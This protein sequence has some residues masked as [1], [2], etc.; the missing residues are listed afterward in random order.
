[1]SQAP[2][3]TEVQYN[4]LMEVVG[5]GENGLRDQSMLAIS[6]K[7]GL[8]AGEISNLNICDVIG[9]DG[10]FRNT[11]FV[12]PGKTKHSRELPFH[13]DVK[14]VLGKY[15]ET[16]LWYNTNEPLF[17]SRV[18]MRFTKSTINA[19][20]KRMFEKGGLPD[21]SSHSGRRSCATMLNK[22]GANIRV[23]QKILGHTSIAMTARY[24][25][26]TLEDLG[27]ALDKI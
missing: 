24:I 15:L 5:L 22:K 20:F 14:L 4:H 8:R 16:F 18:G 2:I 6:F 23:I 7:M 9:R 13:N 12:K 19:V 27:Q 21:F 11:M 3:I 17:I 25:E 10:N 26:A 1:M